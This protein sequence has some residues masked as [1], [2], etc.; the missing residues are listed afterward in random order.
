MSVIERCTAAV[1]PLRTGG[2]VEIKVLESMK[3]GLAVVGTKVAAEGI[4]ASAEEGLVVEKD[5]KGLARQV[6]GLLGD[7][8][9]ARELGRRAREFVST[10]YNRVKTENVLEQV[11]DF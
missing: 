4:D 11:F 6:V 9:R 7:R 2:G 1:A 10:R 8:E 5:A 3:A